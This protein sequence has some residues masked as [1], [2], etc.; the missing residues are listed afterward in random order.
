MPV[1]RATGIAMPV[2][3]SPNNN[4]PTSDGTISNANP[5][6]ASPIAAKISTFFIAPMTPGFRAQR[7]QA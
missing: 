3:C 7:P 1:M 6:P 2:S 4:C 5:A